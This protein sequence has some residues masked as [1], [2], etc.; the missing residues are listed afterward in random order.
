RNGDAEIGYSFNVAMRYFE[1][2]IV[3]LIEVRIF[4]PHATGNKSRANEGIP[5]LTPVAHNVAQLNGSDLK[6]LSTN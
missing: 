2:L 6:S 5:I 1:K 3:N 4:Y